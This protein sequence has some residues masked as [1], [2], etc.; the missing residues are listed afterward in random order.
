MCKLENEHFSIWQNH[1]LSAFPCQLLTRRGA[2]GFPIYAIPRFP[3]SSSKLKLMGKTIKLIQCLIGLA[4]YSQISNCQTP[5][6][7]V[8]NRVDANVYLESLKIDVNIVGCIASTTM[9]MVFRNKTAQILEGEL[10]FPLPENTSVSGFSLDIN[11]KMRDAVPV[12]KLKA[13]QVFESIERRKVDPGLL[14]KVEGNNFRTRV[15]P[16]PAHGTR[17]IKISYEQE[18]LLNTKNSLRYHLP[19]HYTKPIDK[20]SI[21]LSVDNTVLKPLIEEQPVG[22]EFMKWGNVY[23][24]SVEKLHFTPNKSLTFN[25][26]KQ[27]G[28]PEVM[29]QNSGAIYYFLINTFPK[30][31]AR[32]KKL[33]NKITVIWDASLSG[34]QRN[35]AA[36]I[37]LL[38]RFIREKKDIIVNLAILNNS[39]K[40]IKEYHLQDGNWVALKKT[41]EN[42]VYDGGTNLGAIDLNSVPADE[43]LLFSDGLSTFGDAEF[44]LNGKIVHAISS[45]PAADH[46]GL[47]LIAQKTGGIFINLDQTTAVEAARGL[48]VEPYRFISIKRNDKITEVFPSVPTPVMT[49]FSL[50]GIVTSPNET[51]TLQFGFGNEVISETTIVLDPLNYSADKK[52][53]LGRH[54]AQKKIAELDMQYEKN[55]DIISSTGKHFSIVTRNTSLIV[56]ETISDYVQYKIEPPAELRQEYDRV[57]K[58]RAAQQDNG[59]SLMAETR[60]ALDELRQWWDKDFKPLYKIVDLTPEPATNV[61]PRPHHHIADSA[62]TKEIGLPPASTHARTDAAGTLL[63]EVVVTAFGTTRRRSVTGS[64]SVIREDRI[65]NGLQGRVAGVSISPGTQNIVV[66]GIGDNAGFVPGGNETPG[67][68]VREWTPDRDYLAEMKKT[69]SSGQYRQYLKLRSQYLFTPSFYYDMAGFFF[70]QKDSVIGLQILSNIAELE[71]QDHELYKLLGFT[72]K[73]IGNYKD[74]VFVFKKVL[75]WRPQ[76]P[77][78]YRDYGL[79]LAD[80]G[81]YQQA[82][83]TLYAALTETYDAD[84]K[85]IFAGI[86]E[87]IITEINHLIAANKNQLDLSN[88]D[89]ALIQAMPVDV[90]VVLNWNSKDTDIDL[91]VTDPN[92]EKCYY[93]HKITSGGAKLSGDQTDGYGPEQ[94]LLKKAV[95]GKYKIEVDYYSDNQFK[96]S[97]PTTLIVEIY[98]HYGGPRQQRRLLTL[99]M[100]KETKKT[101]ILVGEFDF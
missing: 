82:L 73:Q 53:N 40:K 31:T 67:I 47:K 39:F 30:Y 93:S 20:F 29:M 64:V 9:E 74:A 76:E 80:A 88:I 75:T 41:I 8:N 69:K 94:F 50:A 86:E 66:R 43:Y 34:L 24:A 101:G 38:G 51:V 11:G 3:A 14:E 33:P 87:T 12:E 90:R 44:A 49:H 48:V 97:G 78:S 83:D 92:G 70:R 35:I 1:R 89:T 68:R 84:V 57:I 99:Q 2:T 21:D 5:V 71:F 96:L 85:E 100:D 52:V 18:L 28:L 65:V 59:E 72:L 27:P 10:T 42:I 58:Q 4:F 61:Q 6:L 55:K 45:S 13:T 60:K 62:Q 98:T 77:Q 63:E 19:F 91:W 56:L 54:W 22:F 81:H 36:E 7:K 26:P 95:P 37:E 16:V 79:A 15:Y 23:T 32:K 25:I 17:T 46:S